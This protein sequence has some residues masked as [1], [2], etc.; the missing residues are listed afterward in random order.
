M[1]PGSLLHIPFGFTECLKALLQRRLQDT[2][3]LG[4]KIPRTENPEENIEFL[5]KVLPI[6]PAPESGLVQ[7]E[8]CTGGT[9]PRDPGATST[10]R[11]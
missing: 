9:A 11:V 6:Y 4:C 1:G 7:A 10:A 5:P 2:G 8:T 3:D